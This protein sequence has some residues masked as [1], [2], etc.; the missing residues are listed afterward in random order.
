M[1][2]RRQLLRLGTAALLGGLRCA[3]VQAWG[4]DAGPT[5]LELIVSLRPGG[6]ADLLAR[7]LAPQLQAQARRGVAVLNV[8]G[9]GG[10]LARRR[11]LAAP[12]D[13]NHWLLCPESL[14][15]INP[16]FYPRPADPLDG[17]AAVARL[18]T[19]PSFLLARADAGLHGVEDFARAARTA[20]QPLA[21]ASGGVG[22]LH[23]LAM[24]QLAAR[25]GLRLLHVPY[26]SNTAALQGLMAG[27]VRVVLAG[28]SALE[29][30]A[31][32]HLRM[33]ATTAPRRLATLPGVPALAE[34]LPGFEA[35]NWF[36]LFARC[37]VPS[38][39]LQQMRLHLRAALD[40]EPVQRLLRERSQLQG[41]YLDGAPFAAI[42]DTERR[43][44]AALAARLAPS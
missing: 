17:L 40:H 44:F 32:G 22:T 13:G 38:A 31:G 16:S 5:P 28:T 24:E 8:D 21:Y 41:A 7:T 43:H 15:T 6:S 10:E 4:G 20:A 42:I 34:T 29:L 12:A 25:L 9:A 23:H 14:L 39:A 37:E 27:D 1:P 35:R 18:A 30:V 2:D 11:L 33:L 3:P 26:R 36:G 19:S